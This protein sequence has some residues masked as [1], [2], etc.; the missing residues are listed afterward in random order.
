MQE[1]MNFRSELTQKQLEAIERNLDLLLQHRADIMN[2]L[3]LEDFSSKA[4]LTTPPSDME[5]LELIPQVKESVIEQRTLEAGYRQLLLDFGTGLT[6]LIRKYSD[7]KEAVE[8]E[9]ARWQDRLPNVNSHGNEDDMLRE[10]WTEFREYCDNEGMSLERVTWNRNT[11]YEGFCLSIKSIPDREIWLA[12]WRDP[13]N[14]RIAVNLHFRL[15]ESQAKNGFDV[16]GIFDALK[17]DE[18]II[19]AALDESLTWQREPRFNAPGP[20]VGVYADITPDR[21]DWHRQFEWIFENLE[22]LNKVFRPFIRR[23]L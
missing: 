22:K 9:H 17:E 3:T 23:Y 7:L 1:Q 12:A 11:Q 10:Y 15:R 21:S 19:Q 18:I 8:S 20:L 2:V 5:I 14:R 6:D 16:L 4:L 13:G